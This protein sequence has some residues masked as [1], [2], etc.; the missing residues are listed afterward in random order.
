MTPICRNPLRLKHI[1]DSIFSILLFIENTIKILVAMIM[2][3]Y[4]IKRMYKQ[5]LHTRFFVCLIL[6]SVQNEKIA[7]ILC[8]N[9]HNECSP[10]FA[11][12][13]VFILKLYLV[14][15]LIL[16]ILKRFVMSQN[17]LGDYRIAAN[18]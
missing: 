17:V 5:I 8:A 16:S 10:V 2:K 18:I 4:I 7:P 6:S 9:S 15:H 11:L 13:L 1:Y 3:H 14:L 12:K